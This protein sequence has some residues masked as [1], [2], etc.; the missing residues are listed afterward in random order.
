MSRRWFTFTTSALA[1][2]A[3][4]LVAPP[5]FA[6]HRGGHGGFHGPGPRPGM[7]RPGRFRAFAVRPGLRAA[8]FNRYGYFLGGYP[9]HYRSWGYWPYYPA[10]GP[11][12]TQNFFYSFPY[13]QESTGPFLG[14]Y[15][16]NTYS[17]E[18]SPLP[19]ATNAAEVDIRVP[20]NADLWFNG[21]KT[22]QKGSYRQFE[23]PAL[24][25]DQNYIY[26]IRARWMQDGQEVDQTQNVKV[27]AGDRVMVHFLNPP[28]G[29]RKIPP[30]SSEQESSSPQDGTKP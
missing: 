13:V 10:W 27:R 6:Q 1:V 9:F 17:D 3:L 16:L 20:A 23:T 18:P 15:A 30:A 11:S 2:V 24:Q 21:A 28:S 26:E 4:L 8:P 7:A 5:S 25:P 22:R 29:S 19:L 14:Y 12:Y